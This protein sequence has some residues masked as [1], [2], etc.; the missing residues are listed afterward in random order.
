M[1]VR[2]AAIAALALLLLPGA[3]I[4]ASNTY[5]DPAMSFTAPSNY[6]QAAIPAHDPTDFSDPAV[7]AA[8]A[9]NAG[10]VE[11]RVITITMENFDGDVD[12]FE[13]LSENELRT[14]TDG[15][16]VKKKERTTL[17]NGMPAYWQEISVGT[18][19]DEIKR[20]QYVWADG[21]R[22]VTLAIS[23]RLGEIDEATAKRDLATAYAV[24]Y[25]K[26]RY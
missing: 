17:S 10:K 6:V 19:F 1:T 7:V 11:Q 25:P 12:G 24:L 3:A 16:F 13:T 22:G 26:N 2:I 20:F 9:A 18:G 21:V 8:F 4:G 15:V 23:A 14:Q 5:S